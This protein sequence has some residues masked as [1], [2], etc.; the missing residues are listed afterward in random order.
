MLTSSLYDYIDAYIVAKGTITAP[1]TG[2]TAASNKRN[3]EVVFKNCVPF[4]GCISE[5]NNMQIDN[6]KDIDAVMN[7]YNLIEHRK[8]Y[9][10]TSG[11]L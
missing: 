7:M 10:Q 11:S 3:K 5:I 2:T 4:T 6:V 9:F 1:N 8:N